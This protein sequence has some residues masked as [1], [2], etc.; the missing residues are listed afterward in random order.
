MAC[1]SRGQKCQER[2]KAGAVG[3][4]ILVI[5]ETGVLRPGVALLHQSAKTHSSRIGSV[6]C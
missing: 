1:T 2:Q 4:A 6:A 5:V 3:R